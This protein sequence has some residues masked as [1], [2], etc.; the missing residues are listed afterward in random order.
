MLHYSLTKNTSN[1]TIVLL[2]GFCL[3]NTCYAKQVLFLSKY[4]NIITIDLP[5]FGNSPTIENITINEM[6]NLVAATLNFLGVKKC[7]LFGHSMGG[8]VALAFARYH[9]NLLNGFGLLHSTAAAD[10]PERIEKRKQVIAFIQKQGKKPYLTTFIPSL[11]NNSNRHLPE[12]QESVEQSLTSKTDGIIAATKAMMH[13]SSGFD[14]LSESSVP[15]FFAIGKYDELI[16]EQTLFDQM[17]LP[18]VAK[19]CYLTKSAHMGMHEE[20]ELLNNSM[21][22][23]SNFCSQ[24]FLM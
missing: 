13:R 7:T 3:N 1:N 17:A 20:T 12:V 23:F 15:V 19:V 18:S 14:V 4:A 21:L 11:Y 24:R 5:G 22:D 10:T 8:Y 16:Q 6:A 9:N 2:H